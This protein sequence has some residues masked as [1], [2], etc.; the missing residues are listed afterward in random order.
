[1]TKFDRELLEIQIWLFIVIPASVYCI[2][3]LI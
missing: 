3:R 2:T 1:M